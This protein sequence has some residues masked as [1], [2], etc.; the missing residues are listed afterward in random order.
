MS[1][2]TT[3]TTTTKTDSSKGEGVAGLSEWKKQLI[4]KED[5]MHL[6]K[7]LGILCVLSYLFRLVQTG[8][9]DMGFATMTAWTIPTVLLHLALNVS[10]LEFKIP[11]KRISSGYRIWP[12]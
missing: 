11:N 1:N 4:T 8:E 6:H 5:P 9:T 3:S 2:G 10:A 7:S 12:E